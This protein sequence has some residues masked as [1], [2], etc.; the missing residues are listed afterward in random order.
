MRNVVGKDGRNLNT[1]KIKKYA[2]IIEQL[3]ALP[4][5]SP[6]PGLKGSVMTRLEETRL[7]QAH[8]QGGMLSCVRNIFAPA[9][10]ETSGK[11]VCFLYYMM[12][13][14]FYLIIGVALIA[15]MEK[16]GVGRDAGWLSLQP[17]M[18]LGIALWLFVLGFTLALD[19]RKGLKIVKYGTLLYISAAV[20]F[21]LVLQPY[22]LV[23]HAALFIAGLT[24]AGVIM[25][26]SL[27]ESVRKMELISF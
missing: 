17:Y 24:A 5:R 25:G 27:L 7:P 4:D 15:G 3:E 10:K 6:P 14:L 21:S 19:G 2:K 1:G 12:T 23:P 11:S 26:V 13:G 16:T 22:L 18:A 8:V 9:G 20:F